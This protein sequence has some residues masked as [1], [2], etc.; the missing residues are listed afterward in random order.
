MKHVRFA[1]GTVI[2]ACM[3]LSSCANSDNQQLNERIDR[4]QQE[5]NAMR[6]EVQSIKLTAEKANGRL[7]YIN[8]WQNPIYRPLL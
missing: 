1:S 6:L 5:V 4:L 3:L 2:I 8:T 7:D